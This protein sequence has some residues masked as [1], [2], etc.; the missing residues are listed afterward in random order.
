MKF[1]LMLLAL[2]TGVKAASQVFKVTAYCPCEKCCRYNGSRTAS[3]VS[4]KLGTT[5]AAPRWMP[6]GT[7][8]NIQGVGPRIVQD[9]LA[10]T[11]DGRIDVYVRSH[12][13]AKRFGIKRLRVVYD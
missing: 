11:Y 5:V 8:L 3:G 13:E 6:F 10:K 4:P 12:L 7:K 2:S 9:R 1:L